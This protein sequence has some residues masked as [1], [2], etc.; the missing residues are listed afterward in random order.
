[1]VIITTKLL[2]HTNS[3][4]KVAKLQ[5]ET[6]NKLKRLWGWRLTFSGLRNK[7]K[8]YFC[9]LFVICTCWLTRARALT[10]ENVKITRVQKQHTHGTATPNKYEQTHTGRKRNLLCCLLCRFSLMWG[11][12]YRET[13]NI[14]H[15]MLLCDR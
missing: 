12:W 9:A 6:E 8:H 4:V 1:M 11:I 10:P 14:H 13:E 15:D 5:T 2:N 3:L 7:E